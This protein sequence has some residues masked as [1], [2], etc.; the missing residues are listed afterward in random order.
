MDH[1]LKIIAISSKEARYVNLMV[2]WLMLNQC[3]FTPVTNNTMTSLKLLLCQTWHILQCV[4][5]KVA[6]LYGVTFENGTKG[7][8]L[9]S[10]SVTLDQCTLLKKRKGWDLFLNKGDVQTQPGIQWSD[11][12]LSCFHRISTGEDFTGQTP[13]NYTGTGLSFSG[14]LHNCY[15]GQS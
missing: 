7:S 10:L 14:W 3:I 1:R 9:F 8:E 2:K 15:Q 11:R 12:A 4:D 13:L 5:T 6:T